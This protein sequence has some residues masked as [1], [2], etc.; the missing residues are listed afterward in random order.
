M[1]KVLSAV[2]SLG[3]LGFKNDPSSDHATILSDITVS[4]RICTLLGLNQPDEFTKG[5]LTPKVKV[6]SEYTTKALSKAQV[7]D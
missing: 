5:L 3:N 7:T 6:G 2:L 4:Q 1:L